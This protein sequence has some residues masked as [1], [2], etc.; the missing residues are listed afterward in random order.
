MTYGIWNM[1]TGKVTTTAPTRE[2]IAREYYHP[3]FKRGPE[4]VCVDVPGLTIENQADFNPNAFFE[5]M[6]RFITGANAQ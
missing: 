3:M 2:L 5:G 1:V 4:Q 6:Q